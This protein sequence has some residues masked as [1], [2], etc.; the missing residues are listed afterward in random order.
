MRY[1]SKIEAI[2]FISVD[3]AR[4]A[5]SYVNIAQGGNGP[6]HTALQ[7]PPSAELQS[8]LIYNALEQAGTPAN[9]IGTYEAAGMGIA[10]G[11]FCE[12]E[13]LKRVI[14]QYEC[15]IM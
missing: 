7:M 10:S 12:F 3:L 1:H 13:T 8:R 14:C 6:H 4:F 5:D 15:A 2:Y 9:E 11:D